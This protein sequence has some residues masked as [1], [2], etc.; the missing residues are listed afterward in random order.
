MGA[1]NHHQR[2]TG[3]ADLDLLAYAALFFPG[4]AILRAGTSP[5][6]PA[7]RQ[8]PASGLPFSISAIL[9]VNSPLRA[10]NSLVPSSGRPASSAASAGA[11]PTP[12]GPPPE[13]IGVSG[14]SACRP[15][16][17][18][19]CAAISAAVAGESSFLLATLIGWF[20]SVDFHRWHRPHSVQADILVLTFSTSSGCSGVNSLF[21][22]YRITASSAICDNDGGFSLARFSGK[23][24]ISVSNRI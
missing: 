23:I 13:R 14:S 22:L 5:S 17:M 19:L 24:H 3:I 1:A 2:R 12:A 11:L 15:L 4:F 18:T 16:T 7:H 20:P 8:R 21:Y 9:T 6:S 10:I